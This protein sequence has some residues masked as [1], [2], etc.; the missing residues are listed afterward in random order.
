MSLPPPA[1]AALLLFAAV[2]PLAGQTAATPAPAA[3]PAPTIPTALLDLR[4]FRELGSVLY[5]AAHPDDE[6]TLFL[7]WLSRGRGYRTAYLSLTRGDGGQNVIGPELGDKLGVARTQ[8]LLAGRR[9]DGAQQFFSRALDF[10][11]SKDYADTQRVWGR[12]EV[13]GDM[14]RVIRRF[15]PDIILT[16]FSPQPGGTH[17]HHT[18]SAVLSIDAFKLAGDPKAYPEQ[19]AQ[20]LKPWQPKRVLQNGSF[21]RS[22]PTAESVSVLVEGN[23]PVLGIPLSTL[24]LRVLGEHK[25]QNLAGVVFGQGRGA[26]VS[27]PRNELFYPLAG[28]PTRSGLFE[29]VATTWTARYPGPGEKIDALAAAAESAFDQ[30]NLAANV[31]ALLA[32][33]AALATLPADPLVTD[34]RAQ[35]DRALI[36]CLGLTVATTSATPDIVPGETLALTHTVSSVVPVRWLSTRDS[37]GKTLTAEI[38]VQSKIESQK[39]KIEIPASTPLTTPY[40]LRAEGRPGFSR[41][42]DPAL[43]GDAENKPAFPFSYVFEIAG[44]QLIVADEPVFVTGSGPA[45]KRRRLDIVP[46]VSLTFTSDV[47]VL[48]PGATRPVEVEISANRPDRTGSVALELPAGWKATPAAQPF[49]LATTGAKSRLTFTVTAPATTTSATLG[50]VATIGNATYRH[51]RDE[52]NYP[53][54]PPQVL[55][56]LARQRAVAFDVAVTAKKIGYLPGA[57]DDI[58]TALTQLGC[59]VTTLTD[60]DLTPEKLAAFD[61][62]VTGVR[63]FNVRESLSPH[64]AGLF[65]WVEQGGTVIT[66]YNR[67]GRDIK[68]DRLAPYALTL[69]GN[70]ARVTDEDA[71]ITLLE[72]NHPAFN[73]PNKLTP[74]DWTGWVQERGAYFGTTWGPEFTPL[75]ACNDA[76]EKPQ[77]GGLLVARHGQGYYVYT[78][79]G[80]FR[81]LPAGVPGAY[82]LFANLISL[83]KK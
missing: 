70:D 45:E 66:Q 53:H 7:S 16:R 64:L 65:A 68:T 12:D 42:D 38:S 26:G 33:R 54:I 19:I 40:W 9:L 58:P 51:A 78:G 80:F 4:Q 15:Q 76:G 8:E 81:Q 35:L 74:A 27:G 22:A 57:G 5:V 20:G 47:T 50:A 2:T 21:G 13:I 29:G 18:A 60:A 11:F 55:Q 63:A 3:L 46:P 36:A 44:Q 34:K 79:L 48:T 82:R 32:L 61:A 69:G 10:G 77:R 43:I 24:S 31:P 41:V 49:T 17:G 62:V 59:T 1:L 39:S 37:A 56:P 67:P 6:N 73:F 72:P 52:V 75:L 25:T 23:D 30:K 83:G 28:E 14:V 71:A